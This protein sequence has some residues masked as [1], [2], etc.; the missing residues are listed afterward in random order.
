MTEP[1]DN[2]SDNVRNDSLDDARS[3]NTS[4]L[5]QTLLTKFSISAAAE[6]IKTYCTATRN[7]ALFVTN[8]I[9]L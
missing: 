6:I 3:R 8:T 7:D 4:F 5:F 9:S 1:P 2:I